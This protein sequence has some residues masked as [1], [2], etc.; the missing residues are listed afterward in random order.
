MFSPQH[1][2]LYF[3]NENIQQARKSSQHEPCQTAW[4][5]LRQHKP[6]DLMS[7]AQLNGLRYRFDED[8]EAGARAVNLLMQ[9]DLARLANA[10]D[11]ETIAHIGVLVQCFEMIRDHPAFLD[12]ARVAWLNSLRSRLQLLHAPAP[13]MNIAAQLWFNLLQMVSAIALE[14]E[15]RFQQAVDVFRQ[16]V[17]DEIHPEGYIQKA[18]EGQAG[19]SLYH[20][21]LSAQALVLT[22]E[23]GTHAGENLWDYHYRGVS[24]MTPLPYLLYYYYYPEK[25][26]WEPLE[27]ETAQPLYRRHAGLWEMVQRRS[28]SRDRKLLLDELRPVYDAWGG[29]LTTLTH[30]APV[31]AKRRSLFG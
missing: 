6:L 18:V 9:S 28:P 29:G 22:A 4:T 10:P 2:G 17:S 13:S 16:V 7:L 30:A 31:G 20:M 27:K 23:A 24:V 15:N 11:L 26:R 8:V 21:L 14:D 3:D 5:F 25:W 1:I 19:R 12:E